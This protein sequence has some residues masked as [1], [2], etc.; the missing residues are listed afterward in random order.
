LVFFITDERGVFIILSALMIKGDMLHTEEKLGKYA[1]VFAS[2]FLEP[3][4][5]VELIPFYSSIDVE[6]IPF[7]S[8]IDFALISLHNLTIL[9][10]PSS[11]A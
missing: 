6:L 3:I 8:S 10:C 1:K 11:D 4:K 5:I 9:F 2:F 7:F